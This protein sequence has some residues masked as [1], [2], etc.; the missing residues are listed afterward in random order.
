M[1]KIPLKYRW[2]GEKQDMYGPISRIIDAQGLTGIA[3]R[4]YLISGAWRSGL[5]RM[6]WDHEAVGS[7]PTAPIVPLKTGRHMADSV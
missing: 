2:S 5:A 7:N 1:V 3:G 4:L 6:V